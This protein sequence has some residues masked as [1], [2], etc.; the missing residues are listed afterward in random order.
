MGGTSSKV[1]VETSVINRSLLEVI[2][3]NQQQS[4]S[5]AITNQSINLVG[6]KLLCKADIKQLSDVKVTS[7]QQISATT[8][9]D[10][11]NTLM[12]N[13][14]QQVS[15]AVT[16]KQGFGSLPSTVK[17]EQ[18]AKN[19]LEND[20]KVNLT[21]ENL[22][23]MVNV[24]NSTQKADMKN[25]VVDP[26]GF[27]VIPPAFLKDPVLL[28]TLTECTLNTPCSIN[29]TIYAQILAQQI[30]GTAMTLVSKNTA[31]SNLVSAISSNVVSENQGGL[32]ALFGGLSNLIGAGGLAAALPCIL[33][34]CCCIAI[35][36]ALVMIM[37]SPAVQGVIEKAGD[38]GVN[39]AKAR[40]GKF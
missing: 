37:N 30:T 38:A 18:D 6:A 29:Q 11:V 8:Q 7:L 2:N 9:T 23:E 16:S 22:N 35:I 26:C 13:L 20:F 36:I 14:E 31:V 12:T 17:L 27:S 39:A 19:S 4:T 5:I 40:M 3:K 34:C 24:I 1:K 21:T 33:S 25:L 28:K 10:I 15:S 32:D